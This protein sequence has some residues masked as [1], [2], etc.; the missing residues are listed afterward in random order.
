MIETKKIKNKKSKE[1]VLK[2]DHSQPLNYLF[3]KLIL[4]YFI[5]KKTGTKGTFRNQDLDDTGS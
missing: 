2:L 1:Q 4:K 5:Y 3:I